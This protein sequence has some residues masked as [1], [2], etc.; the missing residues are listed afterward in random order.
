MYII[1]RYIYLY[2]LY[3]IF[4]TLNSQ[5]FFQIHILPIRSHQNMFFRGLL[6]DTCGE[7]L[8]NYGR[9]IEVFHWGYKPPTFT[10]LTRHHYNSI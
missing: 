8:G 1:Y 4:I 10:S 9:D 7:A 3:I 6:S 5:R 2:I